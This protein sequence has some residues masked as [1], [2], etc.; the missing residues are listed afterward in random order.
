MTNIFFVVPAYREPKGLELTLLEID[1]VIGRLKNIA[2]NIEKITILRID[3]ENNRDDKLTLE[4]AKQLSDKVLIQKSSG[5]GAAIAEAIE[6]IFRRYQSDERN[7]FLVL[8]DADHTY[9]L[10]NLHR[11]ILMMLTNERLGMILGRRVY[12]FKE[13]KIL[14]FGNRLIRLAHLLFNRINV[15]DPLSGLRVIR[16]SVL[17]NQRLESKSF[18]IEIELNCIVKRKGY[19]IFEVPILYRRRVGTKKLKLSHAID[20]MKRIILLF[21]KMWLL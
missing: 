11:M 20:I 10:S 16:L 14:V 19:Y 8:T 21:P 3:S 1:E 13:Q 4:V 6:Y 15:R 2:S 5:K 7:S 12:I 9:D 18:D 17:K